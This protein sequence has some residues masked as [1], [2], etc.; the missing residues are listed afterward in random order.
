MEAKELMIGDWVSYEGEY[1]KIECVT[2]YPL[3]IVYSDGR[4]FAHVTV[5][6]VDPILLTEDILLKNDF[7]WHENIEGWVHRAYPK[8]EVGVKKKIEKDRI[9]AWVSSCFQRIEYVHELQH[10]MRLC[11]LSDLADNFKI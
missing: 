10:L 6:N 9:F 1:V 2:N 3:G 7:I 11:G 4:E 5:L 8:L